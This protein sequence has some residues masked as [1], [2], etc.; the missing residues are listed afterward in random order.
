MGFRL[1]YDESDAVHCTVFGL[2]TAALSRNLGQPPAEHAPQSHGGR[3]PLLRLVQRAPQSVLVRAAAPP[4]PP[5]E[6]R[7]LTPVMSL[8]TLRPR[9]S[10]RFSSCV[11]RLVAHTT[12]EGIR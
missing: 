12:E 6:Q 11:L 3:Q 10:A 1:V 5:V 8:Q 7:D 4:F 9:W 2:C